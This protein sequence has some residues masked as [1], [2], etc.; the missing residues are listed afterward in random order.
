MFFGNPNTLD[1]EWGFVGNPQH[2]ISHTGRSIDAMQ[3]SFNN[4]L[5][6]L[7]FGNENYLGT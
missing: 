3:K 1:S 7:V 4:L 2:K 5:R 6:M